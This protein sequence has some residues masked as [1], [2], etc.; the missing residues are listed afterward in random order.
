MCSEWLCAETIPM[1][2]VHSMPLAFATA[3]TRDEARRT[4]HKI[5]SLASDLEERDETLE[6]Q[7]QATQDITSG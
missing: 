1:S 4:T 3:E 6:L 2:H 5:H 7:T